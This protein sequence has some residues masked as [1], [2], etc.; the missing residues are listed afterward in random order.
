M[1]DRKLHARPRCRANHRRSDRRSVRAQA[2]IPDRVSRFYTCHGRQR[3]RTDRC[4]ADRH[5]RRARVGHRADTPPEPGDYPFL[6]RACRPCESVW[7]LRC[8]SRLGCC[9]RPTARRLPRRCQSIWAWLAGDLL[10]QRGGR[11]AHADCRSL[12]SARVPC[13]QGCAARSAWCHVRRSSDGA[14]ALTV[15]AGARVGLA[16]V[17][18]CLNRPRGTGRGPVYRKGAPTR[19]T[20]RP[21]DPRPSTSARPYLSP[22]DC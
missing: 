13:A 20:R 19:C 10:G 17:E 18:F 9:G 6:V 11:G 3:A 14:C 4:C 5:P 12:G 22:A 16:L 21:A 7:C 1:D 2:Y 8:C 15:G